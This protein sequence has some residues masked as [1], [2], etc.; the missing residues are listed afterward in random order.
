MQVNATPPPPPPLAGTLANKTIAQLLQLF[1][2]STASQQN[3]FLPS[4]LA[5]TA[6]LT[7][8]N[9]QNSN[10]STLS[11]AKSQLANQSILASTVATTNTTSTGQSATNSIQAVVDV[12]TDP[13][14][15]VQQKAIV[16]YSTTTNADGTPKKITQQNQY[17]MS[18]AFQALNKTFASNFTGSKQ[19]QLPQLTFRDQATTTAYNNFVKA[20]KS[21]PSFISM[22]KSIHI[23][24][25]HQ[26]Y[27]Y[28]VG[29]Y[30]TL[31]LMNIND[32]KT[33][34]ILENKF[35]LNKKTL[36]L[37][38]LVDL[39]QSQLTKTIQGV[40]PG[41]AEQVAI[42]AGVSAIYNQGSNNLNM[43][44]LD[45]E[46]SAL[47]LIGID[48]LTEDQ[49]ALIVKTLNSPQNVAII[50]S[51]PTVDQVAYQSALKIMAPSNIGFVQQLS[52]DEA[53]ALFE[54]INSITLGSA[55]AQEV[56]A[57]QNII[58]Q[59]NSPNSATPLGSVEQQYFSSMINQISYG[60]PLNQ[61]ITLTG[62][63]AKKVATKSSSPF[64][65][66][67]RTGLKNLVAYL[68]AIFE[69][70]LSG[71]IVQVITMLAKN[72]PENL[73][74]S[75]GQRI[76]L[77]AIANEMLDEKNPLKLNFLTTNDRALLVNALTI[78]AR[79]V[80][81]NLSS[82]SSLYPQLKELVA[83]PTTTFSVLTNDQANALNATL[84]YLDEFVFSPTT[85]QAAENSFSLDDQAIILKAFTAM[86][87]PNFKSFDIFDNATQKLILEAIQKFDAIIQTRLAIDSLDAAA[88]YGV[89]GETP[90]IRSALLSGV[91]LTEYM[92]LATLYEY[93]TITK[94]TIS[95]ASL[96]KLFV[97]QNPSP[98]AALQKSLSASTV[99][100]EISYVDFLKM[101]QEQNN[102]NTVIQQVVKSLSPADLAAYQAIS[103]QMLNKSFEVSD[104]N[105]DQVQLL[106]SFFQ[107]LETSLL[108]SIPATNM[109]NSLSALLKNTASLVAKTH[110]FNTMKYS[111]LWVLKQ[112]LLFFNA[113][114]SSLQ[115]CTQNS[116]Q[117]T[118]AFINEAK[119]ISQALSN[120]L[121]QTINPP[122]FFYDAVSMRCLSLLPQLSQLVD[123]TEHVPYPTF[124]V[125]QAL[126]GSTINPYDGITY[127]N[128]V[129]MGHG[130]FSY[131]K[132]F[133]L[134]TKQASVSSLDSEVLPELVGK[135][136]QNISWLKKIPVPVSSEKITATNGSDV[137]NYD[138]MYKT[139]NKPNDLSGFYM[140]IPV[141]DSDPLDKTKV[142]IRLFE[143]EV[144]D[145]PNWLNNSGLKND[146]DGKIIPGVITVLRGCMGDFLSLVD[147][148]IFDPCLTVIF[149]LAMTMS[150]S[151]D[152]QSEND[153]SFAQQS[154]DCGLYL[155]EQALAQLR[156]QQTTNIQG[157]KV[158]AVS[159]AGGSMSVGS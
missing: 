94:D 142:L 20:L 140:N 128:T 134:D 98:F 54:A 17:Q 23:T 124:C 44:I 147:L 3:N 29:I 88:L 153:A 37:S 158:S 89:F 62:S 155:Q 74:L 21:Y 65:P 145:Q 102:T 120:S 122:L 82:Y 45:M 144:I 148:D 40:L 32:S 119:S 133:F 67:E 41:M 66:D 19:L 97:N 31:S 95:A 39:I 87:D 16:A 8:L 47:A 154:Q 86:K 121:V 114:T 11:A 113:Y 14:V 131:Q 135:A 58:R 34:V 2:G 137:S 36:I 90:S 63:I 25:L 109:N 24:A 101:L 152:N 59:L 61:L 115:K 35:G 73:V 139:Q 71:I 9:A 51:N 116:Y 159:S 42:K 150:D 15:S 112:Y 18:P 93:L 27:Q 43:F 106:L 60:I 7:N 13:H 4:L 56:R 151:N 143:Q 77:Q 130:A 68:T 100:E 26:L 38:Q 69:E 99:A 117:V 104:L 107:P 105:S 108:Q 96:Y 91:S 111:F 48:A 123:N 141:F 132:F 84:K 50:A 53:T 79:N 126:Y 70:N 103:T 149:K 33:Y 6:R 136:A 10:S 146:S 80:P 129:N 157:Q 57:V 49:V 76:S 64:T 118:T 28:L 1:T 72:H 83:N 156:Q 22:F 12:L 75:V 30:V 127:E 110:S 81:S 55:G 92:G 52:D 138:H 125:E 5:T 46:Q 85:L 78:F